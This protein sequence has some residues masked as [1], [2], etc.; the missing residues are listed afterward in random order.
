MK[1]VEKIRRV[2]VSSEGERERR[3]ALGSKRRRE[4]RAAETVEERRAEGSAEDELKLLE[5][6]ERR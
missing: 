1:V 6:M 2:E 3:W 4:G 5:T